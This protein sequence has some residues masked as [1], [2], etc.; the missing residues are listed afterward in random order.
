MKQKGYKL[1]DSIS[2]ILLLVEMSFLMKIHCRRKSVQ[3]EIVEIIFKV[4]VAQLML[5]QIL[6]MQSVSEH[7]F[8][9]ADQ[10][11]PV[12]LLFDFKIMSFFFFLL[13]SVSKGIEFI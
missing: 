8:I 7:V 11:E 9:K 4:L 6:R 1:Y 13:E 2:T 3:S 10:K 5:M 12:N